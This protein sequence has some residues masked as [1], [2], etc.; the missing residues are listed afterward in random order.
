MLDGVRWE[1]GQWGESLAFD[2]GAEA[3]FDENLALDF[4]TTDLT[5]AAWISTETDG[6]IFAEVL[7][8]SEW[9]PNGKTFFIRDGH[10]T[11]DVGWIGVIGGAAG[12]GQSVDDGTWHHVGLTWKHHSGAVTL[13]LD[14]EIAAKGPLNQKHH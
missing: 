8:A 3:R 6:T 10:L 12:S 13:F 14:G 11:F 5:F 4:D 7:E 9:V 2:G 1:P